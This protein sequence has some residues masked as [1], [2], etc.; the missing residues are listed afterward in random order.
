ML[1]VAMG[2]IGLVCVGFVTWFWI[3]HASGQTPGDTQ[4]YILAGLRLNAGH[5][6]YAYGPGDPHVLPGSFGA[7]YP[8][9]S[10]PLIAVFFRPI[11]LLPAN[12]E[13]VWWLL[14]DVLEL[15]AVVALV[16]RAPLVTG[17]ALI[18]LSLSVGMA[19]EVGNVD[20][21]VVPGLLAAWCLIVRRHDD[22]AALIIGLLASLKLTPIILVWWLFVT[23]RRRAAGVAVGCGIV[24]ALVAI[25]GSADPFV[26][27]KFF[28]VTM[29][30]LASP[31]SDLGPLGVARQIG[32]PAVVVAALP[33]ILMVGGVALMWAVRRRPGLAWAVGAL[34]MWIAS[35]VVAIH[36]PALALVAIA[37]V[38]WPMA[39]AMAG[40]S[41]APASTPPERPEPY[42][43]VATST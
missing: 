23:G 20:C 15:T 27:G 6:I 18:P 9:F 26:F 31:G 16:R 33:R 39:R 24:L 35:P 14:M 11:V 8:I 2:T 19:M 13:Y 38:A 22:S 41:Q 37:P 43:G 36:T 10:P 12:G 1:A 32:L 25:V 28:E 7:D 30:N 3:S 4:N 34:L 40:H 21:L 5:P 29:A 17:L 42:R